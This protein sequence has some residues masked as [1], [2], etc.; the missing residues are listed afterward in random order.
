MKYMNTKQKGSI[1][2]AS[3]ASI[4]VAGSVITG[5]TYAL[6]TSESK[7]NIAVSSG[8]VSVVASASELSAHSP[9]LIKSDGTIEDDSE[10]ATKV[11]DTEYTFGNSGSVKL[12][13]GSV[14]IDRM[15]PGDEVSFNIDITNNSNVA[16][17]YRYGYTVLENGEHDLDEAHKLVSALNFTMGELETSKYVGYKCKWT[18]LA[19]NATLDSIAVNIKFPT[20]NYDE[21]GSDVSNDYQDLGATICFVVEAI[22]ANAETIDGVEIEVCTF[23]QFMDAMENCPEGSVIKLVSDIG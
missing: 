17:K 8:R 7:T 5:A 3:L 13:G 23:E 12:D 16:V 19:P 22:Q 10:L 15:T 4:A 9:T 14:L 11:S 18:T 2:L 1:I 20:I 21:E 6:F